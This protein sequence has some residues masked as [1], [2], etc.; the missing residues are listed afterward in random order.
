MIKVDDLDLADGKG[1]GLRG[2]LEVS[3]ADLIEIL[4]PPHCRGRDNKM[5]VE[6]AYEYNETVFTIYNYTNGLNYTGEG[7]VEDITGWYVGGHSH[8][9]IDVVNALLVRSGV[10]FKLDF[11]H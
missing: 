10:V 1:T 3:Y 9:A 5:D 11:W 8:D 2:S 4:G 6:W 7:R